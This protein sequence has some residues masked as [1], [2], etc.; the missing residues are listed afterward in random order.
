MDSVRT[1]VM[2]H[3]IAHARGDKCKIWLSNVLE[4]VG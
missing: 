4:T 3:V 1:V 2:Q